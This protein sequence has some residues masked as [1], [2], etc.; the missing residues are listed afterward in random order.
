[1]KCKRRACYLGHTLCLLTQA[2]TRQ[3]QHQIGTIGTGILLQAR[4]VL[5]TL[6]WVTN[7]RLIRA[8]IC[9]SSSLNK[10]TM[11]RLRT[12]CSACLT[13]TSLKVVISRLLRALLNSNSS[14]TCSTNQYTS[15]NK[16][17]SK[18]NNLRKPLLT[19]STRA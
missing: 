15:I 17:S 19:L 1:M 6:S 3:M 8:N 5:S 4:L 18:T 2:S 14:R 11:L 7:P 16:C 10:T 13:H 12:R 9:L